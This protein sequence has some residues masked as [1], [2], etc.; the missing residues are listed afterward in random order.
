MEKI[1][2]CTPA[3]TYLQTAQVQITGP[4]G[5][6]RLTRCVLDGGS[7]SSFITDAL[8]EELKLQ[9]IEHRELNVLAF[10]S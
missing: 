10:E 9:I 2:V 7:Q 3:F 6:S 4:T 1:G 8:I 5:L